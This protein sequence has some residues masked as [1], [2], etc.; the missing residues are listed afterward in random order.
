M[1]TARKSSTRELV[2][3]GIFTALI[4]VGAF[5]RIPVPL[6]PFTM[7]VFFVIMAGLM[8]GARQAAVST[9]VYVFLGLVGVPIFTQGGGPSYIFQPTVGYL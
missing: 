4:A 8:L 7:Q 6:V 9:G 2:L 3:C 1:T 5:I